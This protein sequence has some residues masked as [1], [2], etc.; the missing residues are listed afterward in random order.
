ML[1]LFIFVQR[2]RPHPEPEESQVLDGVTR[3]RERAD[4]AG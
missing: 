1:L 2:H 4:G 3:G